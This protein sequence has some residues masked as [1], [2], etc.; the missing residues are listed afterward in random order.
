MGIQKSMSTRLYTTDDILLKKNDEL[1]VRKNTM[2][3][4][5]VQ[6]EDPMSVS[7]VVQSDHRQF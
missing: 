5:Y 1:T 2:D 4:K 6:E 3:P 7:M